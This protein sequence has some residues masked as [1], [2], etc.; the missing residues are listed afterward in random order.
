MSLCRFV[1]AGDGMKM[2]LIMSL[3]VLLSGCVTYYYPET[4][5]E[6]GVYYAEDDPSYVVYQGGYP[7]AAYYPWSS[8]DYFYMGF[9]PYPRYAYFHGFPF[10]FSHGYAPWYYPYGY[11]GYYSPLYASYYHYPYFPVWR[12]YNGY[13]SHY[14]GHCRSNHMYGG[15]NRH[16]NNDRRKRKNEEKDSHEIPDENPDLTNDQDRNGDEAYSHY[17][18]TA[19]YAYYGDRGLMIR[20]GETAKIGKSR[21]QPAIS[22]LSSSG[23]VVTPSPSQTT[24]TSANQAGNGSSATSTTTRASAGR[25]STRP[26]RHSSAASTSR[27]SSGMSNRSRSGVRSSS[28]GTTRYSPPPVREKRD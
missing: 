23:I 22:S 5:L 2:L 9:N 11:Y 25:P 12:P 13:C 15:Y 6:D 19:P 27:A 10:G 4:A 17:L 28:R 21:I 18:V 14:S 26:A 1:G 20:S 8:L 24:L 7:G 16:A 3:L